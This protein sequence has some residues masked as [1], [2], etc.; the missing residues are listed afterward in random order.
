MKILENHLERRDPRLKKRGLK[1][2]S[3]LDKVAIDVWICLDSMVNACL[4]R[5]FMNI[6]FFFYFRSVWDARREKCAKYNFVVS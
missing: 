6:F 3:C 5:R 4:Y 2:R 1:A